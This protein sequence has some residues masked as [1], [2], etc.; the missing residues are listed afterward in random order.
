MNTIPFF[1]LSFWSKIGLSVLCG[2]LIGLERQFRGKTA[3]IRTNVLVCLGS[4]LFILIGSYVQGP[5]VEPSRVL[6]QLITGI[7]FLGA[8]VI[9]RRGGYVKGLT[10][11]AVIWI[12]AGI[13]AAIGFGHYG[14]ALSITA[15]TLIVLS[16][17]ELI[18]EKWIRSHKKRDYK[19]E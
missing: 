1:S 2:G 14:A 18:E 3:G 8:G 11:A 13:G 6:S 19:S 15:V 12:L 16:G 10:T 9:L 7:G 17:F 5:N 4:M